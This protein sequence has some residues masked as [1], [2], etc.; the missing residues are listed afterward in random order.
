METGAQAEVN[1]HH[2]HLVCERSSLFPP[3]LGFG[4]PSFLPGFRATANRRRG[5]RGEP[6]WTSKSVRSCGECLH[7]TRQSPVTAVDLDVLQR[8]LDGADPRRSGAF[9]TEPRRPSAN[10]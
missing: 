3:Q 8:S 10:A 1:I 5:G 2:V 7:G 6:G 4:E 9:E